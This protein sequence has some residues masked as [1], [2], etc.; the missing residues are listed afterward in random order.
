MYY[1]DVCAVDPSLCIA[2]FIDEHLENRKV[3]G[4]SSRVRAKV[5]LH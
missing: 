2:M 5:I 1:P 4:H 3:V